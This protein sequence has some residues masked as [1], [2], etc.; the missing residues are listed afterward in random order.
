M[1]LSLYA[2][3]R[4][5]EVRGDEGRRDVLRRGGQPFDAVS[6]IRAQSRRECCSGEMTGNP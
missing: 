2:K 5:G 1:A 3:H 6:D 4:E